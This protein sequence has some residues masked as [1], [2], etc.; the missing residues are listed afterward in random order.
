[1]SSL[2]Q[3]SDFLNALFSRVPGEYIEIRLVPEE[4]VSP[5]NKVPP[6]FFRTD[7]V[8]DA[9]AHCDAYAGKYHVFFGVYPRKAVPP[10]PWGGG[11]IDFVDMATGFFCDLDAEHFEGGVAAIDETLSRFPLKPSLVVG[12]GGGRHAYWLFEEPVVLRTPNIAEEV[13]RV[14]WAIG[15]D[16]G[17]PPEKNVVHDLPR[18]LRV[19][20]PPN[21][22]AKY[23][24]NG[25]PVDLL[26]CDSSV[27]Y[28][29]ADFKPVWER[30]S[31]AWEARGGRAGGGAANGKKPV[32]EF[33]RLIR[34]VGNGERNTSAASLVGHLI[35]RSLDIEE[36][37]A[38]LAL[39]N[40]YRVDPPLSDR[41]LAKVLRSVPKTH[42][43]RHP[44]PEWVGQT[45]DPVDQVELL[46]R[47]HPTT[48]K[49]VIQGVAPEE[50]ATV[51]MALRRAEFAPGQIAEIF[52]NKKW[53]IGDGMI[54]DEIV[55]LAD[56]AAT[57]TLEEGGDRRGQ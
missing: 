49:K 25:A 43:R 34:G 22:K 18:V 23:G 1:M 31:D 14:I 38:W 29:P 56:W 17:I 7:K 20:G 4:N 30:N 6:R 53:K 21:I 5:P 3:A 16:L 39:W 48:V 50:R 13:R 42:N 54:D 41:E 32:S 33:V 51:A 26:V 45:V 8:S 2:P 19:P 28:K 35:S 44:A 11:S 40:E 36:V 55:S 37:E 9:V 15:N 46:R 57:V 12:S 47:V 52:R 24:P 10:N 27:R